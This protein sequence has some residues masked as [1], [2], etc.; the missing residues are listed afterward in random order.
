VRRHLIPVDVFCYL[1]A[2]FGEP[3]GFQNHLRRNTSDNLFHWEFML[4]AFNEDLLISGK[5]REVQIIISAAMTDLD[6]RD[7]ILAIK[8]DYKRVGKR[9]SLIFKSLEQWVVFP[10][11]YIAIADLCADLHMQ[12]TENMGGYKTYTPE[13]G[14]SGSLK[15]E[16]MHA[17]D[18]RAQ[19]VYQS[20]L[21]LSILTPVLAEAFINLLILMLCK[22]EL[23][24]DQ[25]KL[26]IFFR[27]K[28]HV[29]LLELTSKCDGFLRPID[30]QSMTLK[31][32]L[33]VMNKR[34]DTIHGNHNPEREQIERVYFEGT[35]PLFAEPCDQVGRFFENLERQYRPDVIVKDYED[36]HEF[37]AELTSQLEP[38]FAKSLQTLAEDPYPGFDINR[39]KIGVLFPRNYINAYMQGD[40]FDDELAVTWTR[41]E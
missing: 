38:Q 3:N 16:L 20:C 4:K 19:A 32:F 40:R 18:K 21:Q 9:K 34:N 24:R 11:R 41:G 33:R 35:R 12:I 13:S 14:S 30:P 7:L 31:N 27:S 23:R 17:L 26:E 1:R 37:L 25:E 39:K 36:V 5:C 15:K 6:W 8:S 29:R 28:I 22:P 10:N 2:R